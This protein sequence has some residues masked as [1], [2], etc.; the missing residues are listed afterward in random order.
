MKEF[1]RVNVGYIN[2]PLEKLDN[3]TKYFNKG[4]IYIKRDDM[5]GLALGGNKTRKLDYIVKYALDND[6]TTLLTYGAPQTNHGRLTIAAAAKFG[7]K[8]ILVCDGIKPKQAQA[9]LILDRM[10]DAEIIFIDNN[11]FDSNDEYAK[12]KKDVVYN[13]I[14]ERSNEKIL[15]VPMGGSSPLGSYGYMQCIKEIIEQINEQDIKIDHLVCGYG[16]MGT[17]AGLWLGAK[18]YKADFD[19]IGIP[20]FPTPFDFDKCVE[21]INKLASECEIDIVC[22]REDLNIVGGESNNIYAGPA[23][24]KSN[25]AI[26][27]A[28]Y[29]MAKEEAIITD[30]CYTGK[31]TYGM[32]ELIKNDIIKADEN[33]LLLHT[34]G[35]PALFASPHV[36]DM[37]DELWNDNEDVKQL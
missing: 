15:E 30:P 19:I 22:T 35:S 34:G 12:Y 36:E 32:F 10:M 7:L 20:V 23:Y 18:Y 24:G 13:L 6:Y 11:D 25:E 9:N 16:S 4:N 37:Q 21:L 3:I 27:N 1:Q 8:S 33:V 31:V 2:T 17:F 14:V 29:L 28:M 26:R 5:T